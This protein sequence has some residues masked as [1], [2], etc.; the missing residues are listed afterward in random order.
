MAPNGIPFWVYEQIYKISHFMSEKTVNT[1]CQIDNT[2]RSTI[3]MYFLEEQTL[4]WL[5][6]AVDTYRFGGTSCV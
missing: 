2:V 6:A 3:D 1:T 4:E 5:V